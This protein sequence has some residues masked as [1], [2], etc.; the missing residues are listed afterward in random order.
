MRLLY[1]GLVVGILCAVACA[2]KQEE[3]SDEASGAATEGP[4]GQLA[5]IRCGHD[6]KA[7]RD[8]IDSDK[9]KVFFDV[10]LESGAAF[11]FTMI[12][13]ELY[14]LSVT[15]VGPDGK[16]RKEELREL[17]DP[18]GPG[19]DSNDAVMLT[20]SSPTNQTYHVVVESLFAGTHF[21][22]ACKRKVDASGLSGSA[23]DGI[24]KVGE[25]C[26]MSNNG[27]TKAGTCASARHF[28]LGASFGG[29]Y[30]E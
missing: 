28:N 30:C 23:D 14:R 27:A 10:V 24:C 9:L 13:D 2:P 6:A 26:K 11:D 7:A 19:H 4:N 18:E 17:L 29:G 1:L 3:S 20:N 25:P 16:T 12:G 5:E 8:K 22:T 21:T 15:V